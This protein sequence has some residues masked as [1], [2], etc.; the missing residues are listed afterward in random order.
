MG[1]RGL[2]GPGGA[3]GLR[4]VAAHVELEAVEGLDRVDDEPPLVV[5]GVLEVEDRL[6][7]V[8]HL[9][10]EHAA[11]VAVLR[12]LDRREAVDLEAGELQ[13][14]HRGLEGLEAR[15]G[16]LERLVRPRGLVLE[17]LERLRGGGVEDLAGGRA[18]GD[19]VG[20][21]RDGDAGH[22]LEDGH[23]NDTYFSQYSG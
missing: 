9:H 22:E 14:A 3:G 20:D 8:A 16:V 12:G 7:R 21:G 11:P 17:D 6:Q 18:Q 2:L 13:L 4:R 15:A 10:R 1:A 19:G 5:V 23:C